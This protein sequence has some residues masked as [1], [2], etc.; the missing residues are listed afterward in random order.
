VRCGRRRDTIHFDSSCG[1]L[2]FPGRGLAT[3]PPE[4]TLYAQL[5]T[6]ESHRE[7]RPVATS[8]CGGG[9]ALVLKSGSLLLYEA[10]RGWVDSGLEFPVGCWTACAVTRRESLGQVE[11]FLY[12]S[13]RRE[14]QRRCVVQSSGAVREGNSVLTLNSRRSRASFTGAITAVGLRPRSWSETDFLSYIAAVFG[15]RRLRGREM[16]DRFLQ[17]SLVPDSTGSPWGA[18]AV[19]ASGVSERAEPKVTLPSD[20]STHP[21]DRHRQNAVDKR[22]TDLLRRE[23]E[24]PHG[25]VP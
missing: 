7:Q 1:E 5:I 25:R 10:G 15:R 8:S 4:F 18:S 21:V 23:S 3:I 11:F 12:N 19:Q 2:Q 14:L 24:G 22:S 9:L 13:D 20:A 6:P 17:D 16:T